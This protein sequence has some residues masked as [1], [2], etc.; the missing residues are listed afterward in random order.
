MSLI[1]VDYGDVDG[2]DIKFAE[3]TFTPLSLTNVTCEDVYTGLSFKPKKLMIIN[4][5]SKGLVNY[6]DEEISTTQFGYASNNYNYGFRNFGMGS[7]H[8]NELG[9]ITET[10]FKFNATTSDY[11]PL[12]Y[13]AI[14]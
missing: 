9:E 11:T 5:S 4:Q 12:R 14:G 3:G 8:G 13:I 6:Y 10:G 2:N 1:T 7:G